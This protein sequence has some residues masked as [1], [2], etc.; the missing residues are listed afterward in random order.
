MRFERLILAM[1]VVMATSMSSAAMALDPAEAIA[2]CSRIS[3]KDARMECY[4]QVAA[5]QAAGRMQT[6]SAPVQQGFGQPQPQM[7]AATPTPQGWTP[8]I[9]GAPATPRTQAQTPAA[10]FGAASLPRDQGRREEGGADSI[11]A[12]VAA[13]TD[14]GLG[15]WRMRLADGAIWQMTERVSLFRPPAPNE[16]VTIRKGALGGY[17]MDVGKQGS[18]RVTRVR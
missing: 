11:Q 17:L 15:M 12:Q 14:N 5:E 18:V 1:G 6:N 8:P 4:D 13:S 16:T 2:F 7:S 10:G 3:K 9:G